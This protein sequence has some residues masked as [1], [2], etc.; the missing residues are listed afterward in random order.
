MIASM[1]DEAKRDRKME[2]KKER[3]WSSEPLR[4]LTFSYER[5]PPSGAAP[6]KGP[7]ARPQKRTPRS[8]N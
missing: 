2:E 8:K 3:H 6:K 7:R 1:N 5:T 4:T